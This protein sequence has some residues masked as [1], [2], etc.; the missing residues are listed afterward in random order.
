MTEPLPLPHTDLLSP[1]R[2]RSVSSPPTTQRP[3]QQV[4]PPPPE[5]P[6]TSFP[7]QSNPTARFAT[8]KTDE[9]IAQARQ[10]GRP[11]KTQ[12]DTKYCVSVWE[13]WRAHRERCTAVTIPH[14]L[15]ITDSQLTYWLTHLFWRCK[16]R[17]GLYTL[18]THSN[19]SVLACSVT[20]GGMGDSWTSSETTVLL[21]S[22]PLWTLN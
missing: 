16:R 20:C 6:T 4:P 22:S 2:A 9:A 5:L 15:D 3:P 1:E 12:Q 10:D 19:T 7:P 8:P 21:T 17:V 13:E 18:P 14:L 11:K